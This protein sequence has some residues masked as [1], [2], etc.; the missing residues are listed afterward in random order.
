MLL[1][2]TILVTGASRGIGRA[3]VEELL[4]SYEY[5]FV[6]AVVRCRSSLATLQEKYESRIAV[7]EGDLKDEKTSVDSVNTAIQRFGRLDSLILNAAVVEPIGKIADIDVESWK[8]LF[9]VNYFSLLYTLKSA[10]PYL[11]LVCGRVI[12]ISSG[13]STNPYK[14]MGAYSG[15]KAAMN[16]L[17][18]VLAI[19]ESSITSVS[20]RPGVVDTQMQTSLREKHVSNLDKDMHARFM[21]LHQT[22][23]L[24]SPE[25]SARIIVIL[26]L[27]A[28][29]ELSGRYI[30][31]DDK[32]LMEYVTHD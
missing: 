9:D 28:K 27:Y 20:L 22:G 21:N 19:E 11:R 31:Y 23:Q 18:S 1:N 4:K 2:K 17:S 6:V 16:H 5:T 29:K 13:A 12:F 7:V 3:V 24:I 15:S 32:E 25:D 8:A 10:I 30:S 26:A 14:S